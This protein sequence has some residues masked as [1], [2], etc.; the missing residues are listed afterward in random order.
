[1]LLL[2]DV[3]LLFILIFTAP[4]L[5]DTPNK[6]QLWCLF[7]PLALQVSTCS[8]SHYLCQSL[9]YKFTLV[10]RCHESL[11]RGQIGII[12]RFN[13]GCGL[14]KFIGKSQLGFNTVI[15][16][17]VLDGIIYSALAWYL[18]QVSHGVN[19]KT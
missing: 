14:F 12:T 7:P 9:S 5:F 3:V 17:L 8:T 4:Q 13:C 16:M 15:G 10:L 19:K 6:Q 2:G 1:M 18:G 11:S